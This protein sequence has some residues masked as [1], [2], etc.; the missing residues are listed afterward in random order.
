MEYNKVNFASETVNEHINGIYKFVLSRCARTEDAEDLTQEICIKLYRALCVRDDISNINAYIITVARNTLVN[1]YRD[2]S[3]VQLSSIDNYSDTIR[4]SA[5]SPDEQAVHKE[6]I[7]AM[8]RGIAYLSKTQRRVVIE[9]FYNNK[10]V[11]EIAELLNIP[12]GTVKWHLSEAKLNLR[13]GM[14]T[15]RNSGELKFN[16]VKFGLM[17]VNGRTGTMGGTNNFFRSALTQNIAYCIRNEAKMIN[18]IADEL[19]VSPVYVES[20]INFLEEYCFVLRHGKKYIANILIDE[21][22][23]ELDMLHHEMYSEGARIVGNDIFDELMKSDIW[24][25]DGLYI[26]DNDKNFAM[27]IFPFLS[28]AFGGERMFRERATIS[29]DEVA[30]MRPDGAYNIPMASVI[31]TEKRFGYQINMNN[32]CGPCWNGSDKCQIFFVDSEFSG[33]RFDEHYIHNIQHD[34]DL[35]Y[36]WKNGKT[37]S[38]DDYAHL[39][40]IGYIRVDGNHNVVLQTV[41]AD[42]SVMKKIVEVG[43]R[44][45]ERHWDSLCALTKKYVDTWLAATPKHLKKTR[46]FGLQHIFYLDGWMLLYMAKQ[47]VDDGRLIV[48]SEDKRRMMSVMFTVE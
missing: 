30:T 24:D 9:H 46:L 37:L 2:K 17:G 4:D 6:N 7:S 25:M 5:M 42:K 48:P 8:Q 3:R 26:P 21:S 31:D 15:M 34:L 12:A 35:I 39:S 18:E 11:S 19:G 36:S 33:R 10:K 32:W 44:V 13:K 41:I 23:P 38:E 1:Y 45:K 20:E 27:W 28:A 22:T 29:F 40:Q 14:E 16:P 47:L 43:D